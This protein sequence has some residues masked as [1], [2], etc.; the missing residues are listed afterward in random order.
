MCIWIPNPDPTTVDHKAC[1]GSWNLAG[2]RGVRATCRKKYVREIFIRCLALYCAAI[3]SR[4][5]A[6]ASLSATVDHEVSLLKDFIMRLDSY[7]ERIVWSAPDL[8]AS[9]ERTL[10]MASGHTCVP[11]DWNAHIH[12]SQG[13]RYNTPPLRLICS[14][15]AVPQVG[16]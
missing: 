14:L 10:C 13:A 12:S 5:H 9:S 3:L 16:G 8:N 11:F 2:K 6:M 4:F 7:C 1:A 15:I